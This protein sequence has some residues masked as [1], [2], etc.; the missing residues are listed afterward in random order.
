MTT[1]VKRNLTT[2]TVQVFILCINV[3]KSSGELWG[4]GT[5]C[6]GTERNII[7]KCYKDKLQLLQNSFLIL[8][9][10]TVNNVV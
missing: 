10:I 8:C 5:F 4:G 2:E 1:F 9:K 7:C 3:S 6:Y